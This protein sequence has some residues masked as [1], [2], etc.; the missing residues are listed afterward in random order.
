MQ[1]PDP[2]KAQQLDPAKFVFNKSLNAAF[3]EE[4]FEGDTIYAE[5][6]FED[7]LKDLPDYWSSVE[8]AYKRSDITE[9]STA[10]HKCKTLFGYVGFTD[11]Q[12]F[13]QEFENNCARKPVTALEV[14]YLVLSQKKE[15]ARQIIESEYN[16]LKLFNVDKR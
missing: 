12:E 6:I 5:T 10:I 2:N 1:N 16:R 13:C 9:L 4:L 11:I 15:T 3:L 14:G 7:F 8:T